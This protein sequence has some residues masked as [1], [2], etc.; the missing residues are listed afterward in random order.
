MK[1]VVH[2]FYALWNSLRN[3]VSQYM[4][5]RYQKKSGKSRSRISLQ[6]LGGMLF[7]ACHY[8]NLIQKHLLL[9]TCDSLINSPFWNA[10]LKLSWL[11][12]VRLK[13]IKSN[14]FD[15]NLNSKVIF[16][17]HHTTFWPLVLRLSVKPDFMI[18]YSK[19]N[20]KFFDTSYTPEKF[21][22]LYF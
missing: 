5:I 20:Y 7:T 10:N 12:G 22:I 16:I 8:I 18:F 13:A 14:D 9:S 17:K 3:T 4:A 19:A 2:Y 6:F 21:V 11:E 1:L 15:R